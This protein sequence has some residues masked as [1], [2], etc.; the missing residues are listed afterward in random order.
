[1]A[2]PKQPQKVKLFIGILSSD[3]KLF[4][5]IKKEFEYGEIDMKVISLTGTLQNTTMMNWEKT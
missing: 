5:I 3:T 1:M 2:L 4:E